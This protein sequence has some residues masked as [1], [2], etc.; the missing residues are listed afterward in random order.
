MVALRATI[1]SLWEIMVFRRKTIKALLL[2]YD[3]KQT[4]ASFVLL[5]KTTIKNIREIMVAHSATIIGQSPI[6]ISVSFPV[7]KIR[8]III[9]LCPMMITVVLRSK[10]KEAQ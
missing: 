4:F 8:E 10:T 9:G 1:I 6:M 5:R 7:E 3:L 2:F